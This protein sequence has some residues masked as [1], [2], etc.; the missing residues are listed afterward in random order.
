MLLGVVA[1]T[2]VSNQKDE[3]LIGYKFQIV[4]QVDL[5]GQPSGAYVVAVDTVG[6]GPGEYV[7]Y[8]TGSSARQTD[9]TESRPV[10][11]TIMAIV[12]MWEVDGKVHYSKSVPLMVSED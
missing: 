1:G 12:D 3:R 2:V 10:D 11:A 4:K 7:L 9:A 6:V 8:A 5:A